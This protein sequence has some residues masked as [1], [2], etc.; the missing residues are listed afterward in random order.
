MNAETVWFNLSTGQRDHYE[1]CVSAIFAY[2]GGD[3]RAIES[4][5]DNAY[6]KGLD[7]RSDVVWAI[8]WR[9]E[10]ELAPVPED[11]LS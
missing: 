10:Q 6:S 1:R 7:K 2:Y 4:L 9:I 5:L 3:T 8:L 11:Y